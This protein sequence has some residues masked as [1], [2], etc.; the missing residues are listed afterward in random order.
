VRLAGRTPIKNLKFKIA[1]KMQKK[2][3]IPYTDELAAAIIAEFGLSAGLKKVWKNRGH[4]PGDYLREDRDDTEGLDDR[5]PEYQRFRE[6]L[7]RPEIASTKFRTLGQKGADVQRGKDRMTEAERIAFKTEVTEI[8]N[9]LRLAK[10]MPTN[11]NL[12]AALKDVRLHPTK[13]IPN[14][15]YSKIMRDGVLLDFEKQ[16]ARVAILA[17]YNHI[18]V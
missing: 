18:R 7:G 2:E 3:K 6:I 14:T 9:K 12:S 11:K 1:A 13:V 17:L 8:R 5:D 4:I 15:L 10:D 16:E